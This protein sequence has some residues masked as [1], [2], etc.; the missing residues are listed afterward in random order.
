MRHCLE[1]LKRRVPRLMACRTDSV[2][3]WRPSSAGTGS[4][5]SET[6][7][8]IFVSYRRQDNPYAAQGIVQALGLRFG[9][10]SVVFVID[11]IPLGA[12]FREYID[13]QVAL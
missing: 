4:A 9:S 2:G 1:E 6:V 5:G 13:E 12:D 11:S 8:K 7:P 3:E 10:E